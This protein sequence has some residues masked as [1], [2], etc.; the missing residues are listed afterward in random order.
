MF[1]PNW[2][3][4]TYVLTELTSPHVCSGHV[5]TRIWIRKYKWW[6]NGGPPICVLTIHVWFNYISLHKNQFLPVFI[7]CWDYSLLPPVDRPALVLFISEAAVFGISAHL[8]VPCWQASCV[9]MSIAPHRCFC[10]PSMGGFWQDSLDSKYIVTARSLWCVRDHYD[11][12]WCVRDH[13]DV[14]WC[15]RDHYDVAV[16]ALKAIMKSNIKYRYDV[17]VITPV[18][19]M[20]SLYAYIHV[21]MIAR[22]LLH[23]YGS[24]IV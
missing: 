9:W 22:R 16:N 13:Y 2:P 5:L 8:A 18:N 11:V 12:T 6:H 24:I 3:F 15:V 1:W 14:T 7:T 20:M 23:E 21:A 10:R 4:H 17:T 19:I